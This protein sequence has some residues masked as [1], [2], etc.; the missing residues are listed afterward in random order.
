MK[1][2]DGYMGSL[3]SSGP[4]ALYGLLTNTQQKL[5]VGLRPQTSEKESQIK[6]VS[7]ARIPLLVTTLDLTLPS[8]FHA[9]TPQ[10]L[11]KKIHVALVSIFL[12]PFHRIDGPIA[13]A[14]FE[15]TIDEITK[16]LT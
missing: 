10:Q 15:N 5:I 11:L 14:S 6:Q 7:P 3:S 1:E 16:G 8:P 9:T 4:I 12:N 13:L 2:W